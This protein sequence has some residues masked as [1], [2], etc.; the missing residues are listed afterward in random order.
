MPLTPIVV[1]LAGLHAAALQPLEAQRGE[2][3]TPGAGLSLASRGSS[4][5]SMYLAA[6]P[7]RRKYA[8]ESLSKIG[9]LSQSRMSLATTPRSVRSDQIARGSTMNVRETACFLSHYNMYQRFL[10]SDEEYA[11]ILEDDFVPTKFLS[12]LTSRLGEAAF[13]DVVESLIESRS[14]YPWDIVNLAR[15]YDCCMQRCEVRHAEFKK[16][17]IA[18]VSSPHPY[19]GTAYLINRKAAQL[20]SKSNMPVTH[21]TDDNMLLHAVQGKLK[22]VSATPR[23]IEQRR[24]KFG[25]TLHLAPVDLECKRCTN[26]NCVDPLDTDLYS[27][28]ASYEIKNEVS[29]LPGFFTSNAAGAEDKV[30]FKLRGKEAEDDEGDKPPASDKEERKLKEAIDAK[31]EVPTHIVKAEHKT[32]K[33]TFYFGAISMPKQVPYVHK[34]FTKLGLKKAEVVPGV[35]R[36]K[37]NVSKLIDDGVVDSH[38]EITQGTEAHKPV[39]ELATTFAHARAVKHFLNSGADYGVI[40]ED[41][42]QMIQSV[43]PTI[44][45]GEKKKGGFMAA[46]ESLVEK[47]PKDFDE[48]NLGRCESECSRQSLVS[49]VSDKAFLVASRYQYCSLAYVLSRTG[50]QKVH[51]MLNDHVKYSNDQLKVLAFEEGKYNQYSLQPRLFATSGRCGVNSCGTVRECA[52][53]K[54]NDRFNCGKLIFDYKTGKEKVLDCSR[55]PV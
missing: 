32:K 13:A 40:F 52:N 49:R 7:H 47:A 38:Y 17:G 48:L 36:S 16:T 20:L 33:S 12:N 10:H 55:G 11:I 14:R 18:L 22:Y 34:F 35:L 43:L 53:E 29:R 3:S 1:V 9:M 30:E 42:V 8:R 44:P 45:G 26:N 37:L 5:Y 24:E 31:E 46:I 51:T 19:C 4:S 6:L 50:A 39:A 41:D 27:R 21:E 54:T 23:L 25:S 2:G 28:D 15:C